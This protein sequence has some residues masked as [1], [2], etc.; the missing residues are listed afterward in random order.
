MYD[1][2]IQCPTLPPNTS[3]YG[4]GWV[5]DLDGSS[6]VRQRWDNGGMAGTLSILQQLGSLDAA[7]V[8]N[9]EVAPNFPFFT[10]AS[11]LS[12]TG[13]TWTAEDFFDSPN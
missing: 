13:V 7:V 5:M 6:Q 10:V 3:C 11:D 1:P 4:L 12:A 8:T 9:T 2:T